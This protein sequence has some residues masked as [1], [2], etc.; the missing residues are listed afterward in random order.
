MSN[1]H[2]HTFAVSGFD[3]ARLS[4]TYIGRG[5]ALMRASDGDVPLV[6][7]PG[8]LR[9]AHSLEP[10]ARRL[11]QRPDGPVRTL[12][13]DYRG[14]GPSE[15]RTDA[16]TYTPRAEAQDA[17]SVL[18]AVNWHHADIVASGRGGLVALCLSALRPALVRRLVLN[19]IGPELDGIGLARLKTSAARFQVPSDWTEAAEEL[20][21]RIGKRYP[22]LSSEDYAELARLTYREEDGAPAAALHPT[23]ME[24]YASIDADERYPTLWP[25]W[26]A[27]RRKPVLL[28]RAENSDILTDAVVERMK[29]AH[30]DLEIETVPGQGHAPVLH[31]D[32]TWPE[33]IASFLS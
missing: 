24:Q 16:A 31:L 33:R 21:R 14:R 26:R 32:E 25:E 8:H 17:V 13:I 18:D 11:L 6:L 12:L 30:S 4:A 3:G 2:E 9:A 5:D 10:L 23:A 22:A 27:L 28:L 1:L 7:L 15:P 29:A 19:D 20:Q